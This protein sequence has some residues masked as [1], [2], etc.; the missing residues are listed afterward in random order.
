MS[1][2]CTTLPSTFLA[3]I[4]HPRDIPASSPVIYKLFHVPRTHCKIS[5]TLYCMIVLL[6]LLTPQQIS[7]FLVSETLSKNKNEYVP[8][9]F[10]PS[11]DDGS[12]S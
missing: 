7:M 4:T 3:K 8:I 2:Y 12:G 11:E 10:Q 6:H 5:E 9:S 1:C